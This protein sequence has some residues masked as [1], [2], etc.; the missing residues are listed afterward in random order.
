MDNG[1]GRGYLKLQ[2]KKRKKKKLKVLFENFRLWVIPAK[3]QPTGA[4]RLF[5]QLHIP[6][7]TLLLGSFSPSTV[8]KTFSVDDA[9]C[10]P[11]SPGRFSGKSFFQKIQ[12]YSPEHRHLTSWTWPGQGLIRSPS[13]TDMAQI[14]AV[15]AQSAPEKEPVVRRSRCRFRHHMAGAASILCVCSPLALGRICFWP[16]IPRLVFPYLSSKSP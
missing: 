6:Y 12:P 4:I 14:Q 9:F 13:L 10:E 15:M 16:T 8:C 1:T 11:V 3:L 5:K 2:E 7:Y